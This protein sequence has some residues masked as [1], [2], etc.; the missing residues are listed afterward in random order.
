MDTQTPNRD[1]LESFNAECANCGTNHTPLWRKGPNDERNC[2]ACGLYMT[3]HKSPR[4]FL[5]IGC[6]APITFTP[7]SDMET[8][9]STG[10]RFMDTTYSFDFPSTP[11]S[12][13]CTNAKCVDC[14]TK[15]SPLWRRGPGPDEKLYCNACGLYHRLV[16]YFSNIFLSLSF[17]VIDTTLN[18]PIILLAWYAA[19]P[20][21]RDKGNW[22]G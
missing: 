10:F 11:Y 6:D 8:E 21:S 15:H 12:S 20:I 14:G 5:S 2:N 9:A 19:P 22:Y 1:S 3:L 4:P 16:G 18:Y 17:C 7:E 13:E